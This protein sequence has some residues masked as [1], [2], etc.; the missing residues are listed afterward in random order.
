MISL[1]KYED[2]TGCGACY[3]AC[4]KDAIS[5]KEVEN[6]FLHPVIDH[7]KCIECKLCIKSYVY[8]IKLDVVKEVAVSE[9][10][11][12]VF[13]HTKQLQLNFFIFNIPRDLI[14][15]K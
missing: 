8:L 10:S 5:M 13:T 6:G 11:I 9:R 12:Y 7:D 2:C 15:M 1:C 14:V 4:P 3:N